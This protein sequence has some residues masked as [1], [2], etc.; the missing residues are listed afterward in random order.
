[1]LAQLLAPSL[2][3][4]DLTSCA[5]LTDSSVRSI[6]SYLPGLQVLRLA[7]C[8]LITDWGLLGMEEPADSKEP[9]TCTVR[10][11]DY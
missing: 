5:V 1:M 6:S 2:R 7:A 4:L 3:E 8:K 11:L 10:D 9:S